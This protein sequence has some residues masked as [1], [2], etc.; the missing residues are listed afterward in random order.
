MNEILDLQRDLHA[1]DFAICEEYTSGILERFYLPLSSCRRG[2]PFADCSG[3]LPGHTLFPKSALP[4]TSLPNHTCSAF[5]RRASGPSTCWA[6]AQVPSRA[7]RN[8]MRQARLAPPLAGAASTSAVKSSSSESHQR[9]C[10]ANSSRSSPSLSGT[11]VGVQLA[12]VDQLCGPLCE[13]LVHGVFNKKVPRSPPVVLLDL[14][15]HRSQ[16]RQDFKL[17]HQRIL[18]LTNLVDT[19]DDELCRGLRQVLQH[20]AI[21]CRAAVSMASYQLDQVSTSSVYAEIERLN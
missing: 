11:R 10:P 12:I 5:R 21:R 2:S 14:S 9:S 18:A 13:G 20:D 16:K 7:T 17:E 1:K 4:A 8:W 6:L 19:V 15:W 3:S